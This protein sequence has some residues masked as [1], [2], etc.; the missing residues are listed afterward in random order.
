VS[1]NGRA[2]RIARG[3]GGLGRIALALGLL[4]VVWFGTVTAVDRGSREADDR[5]IQDREALAAGFAASIG[6]WLAAGR[7]EVQQLSRQVSAGSGPAQQAAIQ[8]FLRQRRTFTR[9]VMVFAGSRVASASPDRTVLVGLHPVACTRTTPDGAAVTE[10]DLDAVVEQARTRRGAVVSRMFD[11]P[12]PRC[13]TGAV[14]ALAA[15]PSVF[16]VV[17]D[18]EDARERVSAGSL[19]AAGGTRVRLI[20]RDVGLDPNDADPSAVPSR[21]KGLAEEAKEAGDPI[22]GRYQVGSADV[23]GV[24]APIGDGWYVAL[25]QDAAVFD[26]ELQNRPS[27]LV[28]SVLTVVFGVVFLL[29]AYFDVRRRRA[30]RRSDV[31]KNAFFSIAGHELRTPLTSLKGFAE[32]LS[33]NWNDLDED[34]RRTLVD[35][36][37]PQTRRLDRLV[38]RLLVAASIQAE[39]HIRPQIRDI[40]PIPSLEQAAE[41][42][43]SEAPLHEFIVKHGRKVGLAQADP[44]AL[45]QVL[46]HLVENAVKYS[47]SGGRVWLG[48]QRSKRGVELVVQDE[49]IGLPSDHRSIFDKFVQGES[50]TKRVHD[51]GGVGLGLYIVR[52]LVTD[53]GGSVRAEPSET[54][55]ARFVVTLRPAAMVSGNGHRGTRRPVQATGLST[56]STD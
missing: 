23:V 54:G 55:G 3:V 51:E 21:L 40:D 12:G 15:G 19:I 7:E 28:A 16:V 18:V 9:S 26:I 14:V 56:P 5:R 42:F 20:S 24:V 43:R 4:A 49:G 31:A 39:T 6:D 25:E 10:T 17:G 27:L 35:R 44:R 46:Q 48:A 53:M 45:D 11:V 33:M 30:Q 50:V 52:T 13:D 2:G 8:T 37:A 1:L 34:R 47:P 22:R 36:M 32:M 29:V 38:E 41:Q